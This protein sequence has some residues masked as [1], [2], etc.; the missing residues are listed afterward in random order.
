MAQELDLFNINVLDVCAS[1]PEMTIEAGRNAGSSC[2]QVK[3]QP[4]RSVAQE[5][6][7]D[8]FN[9]KYQIFRNSDGSYSCNRLS[10]FFQKG[11]RNGVGFS[12]CKHIRNYLESSPAVEL[13]GVKRLSSQQ[14]ADL[15]RLGVSTNNYLTDV[16]A[17]FLFHLKSAPKLSNQWGPPL[18]SFFNTSLNSS[19]MS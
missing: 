3:N 19:S 17:H 10:F 15:E 2:R 14:N 4:E 1:L 18:F 6:E 9:G 13:S 16:Q 5:I 7:S 12:T 8:N 11:V